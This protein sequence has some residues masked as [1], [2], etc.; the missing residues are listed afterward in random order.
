MDWMLK[1]LCGVSIAIGVGYAC[2]GDCKAC[3]QNLDYTNDMRHS[4][5]IECKSC[6]THEKMSQIDMGCGQ[7]CFACHDARK[8]QAPELARAHFAIK[9]CIQCHT[10]ISQSPF[11]TGSN[12]F[13]KGLKSY[14]FG[15][16]P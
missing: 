10:Q 9:S 12:V 13:E 3:H 14:S 6:H 4:P 1:I 2:T 7:D 15:I 8:T 5:M 16:M 11:D